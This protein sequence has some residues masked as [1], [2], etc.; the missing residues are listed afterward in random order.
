MLAAFFTN[1]IPAILQN[2]KQKTT[3][4]QKTNRVY[5]DIVFFLERVCKDIKIMYPSSNGDYQY[6]RTLFN[7]YM[8]ADM[9]VSTAAG[10]D[11]LAQI[12]IQQ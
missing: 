10:N 7:R 12:Q 4:V 3:T 9:P 11:T 2:Q 1:D 5:A 6:V 8:D